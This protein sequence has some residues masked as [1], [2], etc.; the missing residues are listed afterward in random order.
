MWLPSLKTDTFLLSLLTITSWT[1]Y[2]H[3]CMF[4]MQ[5]CQAMKARLDWII[6]HVAYQ[7]VKTFQTGINCYF[8][9][10]KAQFKIFSF[11][12]CKSNYKG[13]NLCQSVCR[14]SRTTVRTIGFT[15]GVCIAHDPRTC[16]VVCVVRM[17]GSG[18]VLHKSPWSCLA[19]VAVSA[20]LSRRSNR[21]R[22]RTTGSK[23]QAHTASRV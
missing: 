10:L 15:L 8:L 2:Y 21:R 14:L 18:A 3:F 23:Q 11:T 1:T 20:T 9:Q 6:L 16:A 19:R 12:I 7:D 13:R 22:R 17:C 5:I 4:Y